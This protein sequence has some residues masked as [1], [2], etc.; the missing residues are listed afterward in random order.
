MDTPNTTEHVPSK[1]FLK[2]RV[3][4]DKLQEDEKRIFEEEI[5][6]QKPAL[7]LSEK[8]RTIF[9]TTRTSISNAL[10]KSKLTKVKIDQKTFPEQLLDWEIDSTVPV[11][12][13]ITSIQEAEDEVRIQID[14]L[15]EKIS[16]E[17]KIDKLAFFD[18]FFEFFVYF[19]YYVL[20]NEPEDF[21]GFVP[22][23]YEHRDFWEVTNSFSHLMFKWV[24][25]EELERTREK[26]LKI[27]SEQFPHRDA[28]RIL[29]FI[30]KSS[31]VE[32]I[33]WF[34]SVILDANRNMN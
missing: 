29:T 3:I 1:D 22:K 31:F 26:L 9:E 2:A 12:L 10:K 34:R 11:Y 13:T 25:Y 18:L 19:H 15:A 23:W 6:K 24:S 17:F 7:K 16:K 33:V 8:L 21:G 5:G 4:Y 32:S 14:E 30:S 27:F 20:S 28:S